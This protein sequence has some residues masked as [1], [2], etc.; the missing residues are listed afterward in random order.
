VIFAS[1]AG[2]AKKLVRGAYKI[3]VLYKCFAPRSALP[4][5]CKAAQ[6]KWFRFTQLFFIALQ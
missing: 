6:E 2:E 5:P 1:F 4:A 3:S